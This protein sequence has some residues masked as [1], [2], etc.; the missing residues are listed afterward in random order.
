MSTLSDL[1]PGSPEWH[2]ARLTGIGGSD[3]PAILGISNWRTPFDVYL[4]KC[5]E[6]EREREDRLPMRW[7]K[8]LEPVIRQAYANETG[9]EVRA[10]G[11]LRHPTLSFIVGNP[12]GD[13]GDRG[14]ECK[15]DRWGRNWGEPGTDQVPLPYIAQAQHYMLLMPRWEA[16]DFGVPIGGWDFR[17][18]TVP[19]DEAIQRQIVEA[20]S[21]FWSRVMRREPPPPVSPADAIK[22]WGRL[23]SKG[24]VQATDE[25]QEAIERMRAR[26]AAIAAATRL[27]DDDKTLIMTALGDSGDTLVGPDGEVLATWKLDKGA[28]GYTVEPRE[29]A[30][31]FTL[32]KEKV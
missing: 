18:Y 25:M 5:G 17:I 28:K 10:V 2:A 9:R 32:A 23:A 15:L 6:G 16:I 1:I 31:K 12:D 26:K 7:G 20:E 24:V 21:E 11:F 19:R 22:R 4:E 14:L 29:P 3:C 30:R 27:F 13:C 8:L